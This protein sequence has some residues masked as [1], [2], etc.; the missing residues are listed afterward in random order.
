[1]CTSFTIKQSYNS[2]YTFTS[3]INHGFK[4]VDKPV[5]GKQRDDSYRGLWFYDPNKLRTGH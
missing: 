2:I 4:C 3:K 5:Q 1:M